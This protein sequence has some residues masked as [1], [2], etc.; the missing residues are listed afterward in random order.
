MQTYLKNSSWRML[1]ILCLF[2]PL[3]SGRNSTRSLVSF[4]YVRSVHW[5]PSTYIILGLTYEHLPA[6]QR[7]FFFFWLQNINLKF[8]L[9]PII[10]AHSNKSHTQKNE[11]STNV[12][13]NFEV[14]GLLRK[15][16]IICRIF[17]LSLILAF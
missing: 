7:G 11:V 1:L 14:S 3:D 13:E 2:V 17:S 12:L 9:S 5:E 15:N 16:I 6:F 10:T 8:S 4:L